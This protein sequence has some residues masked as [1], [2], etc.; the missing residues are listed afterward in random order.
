MNKSLLAAGIAFA[1]SAPTQAD[2]FISEII[3]GSSNN[4][5]IEIANTG[6]N[7][8][9]LTGY[10]LAR[11]TNGG[12]SLEDLATN[13]SFDLSEVTIEAGDVYV[14]AN[15]NA[16]DAILAEADSTLG[17]S[18]LNFNG[19]D[20]IALFINGVA[21]DV[22]GEFGDVDW[23]PNVTLV[24]AFD[25]TPKTVYNSADWQILATDDSSNLGSISELTEATQATAPEFDAEVTIMQLQG[26]GESSPFTDPDNFE[27][28]S[29][30]VFKVTGIVT[31]IQ[32][33]SLGSDLPVGFFMQDATGDGD[34]TT[35]DGIFVSYSA[36]S[37]LDLTVG[38]EVV[39]YGQA[40]E[41][42]DWTQLSAEFVEATGSNNPMTATTLE[43]LD[44]DDDFEDTLE[45]YEGM[46]IE[47][48]TGSDM[49]ITR[50]FGFDFDSFRNNMVLAHG[51][52]N[53]QPNQNNNPG[54]AGAIEQTEN[55]ALNRLFI[56]T[57]TEA[58]DGV[59]P[60]YEDFG[61]DNGTGTTEDY[62][63]VG[64]TVDGMQGFI[65]YSFSEFRLYV[66]NQ[67]T[68]E[69]FD[70]E[71]V[72]RTVAPVIESGDLKIATFNVLNY[73]NS[74]VGGA[75][76]PNGSNRGAD[77]ADDLAVQ[78]AKIVAAL[79]ALDA[80]FVGLMEV[81]NNGFSEDSAIVALVTALNEALD[82]DKQYTI[83][84]SE[85]YDYIGTDAITNQAIYRANKLSLDEF[86]VIEMPQQHAPETGS[87]SGDNFMRDAVTPT[88]TVIGTDKKL[89]ISVNHLK[90]KGS[91]CYEDVITD[92]QLAD[93]DLQG[94]CE[95]FRVS[96]A[97]QLA[98]S[99]A[100]K[101][102]YTMIVGDL[103]AYA[104]EDPLLLLTNQD[105]AETGY[106]L[107]AAAYTYIGGDSDELGEQLHGPDGATLTASYGYI[108]TLAKFE[109]EG[110]SYSF[111]D[112]V[113]TLDYILVDEELGE[114][115]VDAAHWNINSIES[116]LF[117]YDYD[118]GDVNIYNDA[119]RS[120]DHDPAIIVLNFGIE[121]DL[122]E[123]I[124]L[125][126]EP[127]SL[128]VQTTTIDEDGTFSVVVDLTAS[129]FNSLQVG[130]NVNA[131][132]SEVESSRAATS[133]TGSIDLTEEQI[134]QGWATVEVKETSAGD[135]TVSSF[136]GDELVATNDYTLTTEEDTDTD[137]DADDTSG[138]SSNIFTLLSLLGFAG[139][140]LRRRQQS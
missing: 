25:Q 12:T 131:V 1:L 49:K 109:E 118:F 8:V 111:N 121:S 52:I 127:V 130:T 41:S 73:F 37:G 18:P 136:I 19:D 114:L 23:N 124:S 39:A 60:W 126:S 137:N 140:R 43:T 135:V 45:R 63:R 53:R 133:Q 80:D 58:E 64:A 123:S 48:N 13:T 108:D 69:N 92:E 44:T 93:T 26:N 35:S 65:G 85:D 4:K 70:H 38:D 59:V 91:T 128:P 138:G 31:H 50:T 122:G 16:N 99:L 88:F 83:A 68:A 2:I 96:G 36:V 82:E 112:E 34:V 27:F 42:F 21:H 132:I 6:T 66:D 102:G 33:A 98:N 7:A 74:E 28:D 51:D 78:T 46:F 24:R 115:V 139:W 125:P 90:S 117:Q 57:A 3:E 97:F 30:E 100:E 62:L 75:E 129:T 15:T 119:Y 110:L 94:S 87:E 116:G 95:N 101:E 134:T 104:S 10:T 5:A 20:P 76:N 105:N 22:A 72:D 89:T 84:S 9:T 107:K 29:E 120:S 11:S 17:G 113:G 47:L 67:L 86:D 79:V 71:G 56:E 106:E 77:N 32:T 54:S 40:T 103:N 55:N 61:A 14:L 81:E